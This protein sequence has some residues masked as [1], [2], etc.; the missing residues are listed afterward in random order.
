MNKTLTITL[1]LILLAA[2]YM[3]FI[4]MFDE[5]PSEYKTLKKIELD[6]RKKHETLISRLSLDSQTNKKEL[7]NEY[8]IDS[9]LWLVELQELVQ[10]YKKIGKGLSMRKRSRLAGE[11]LGVKN[12]IK[13]I[14]QT[15]IMLKNA[16][17]GKVL[18]EHE[19]LLEF[20]KDKAYRKIFTS[21]PS[22]NKKDFKKP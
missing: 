15:Q 17:S 16:L 3:Y 7:A 4:K 11:A 14:E 20:D 2:S 22:T 13:L 1:I 5:M 18:S 12:Q 9:K 21:I 8:L 10:N 6:L 19:K